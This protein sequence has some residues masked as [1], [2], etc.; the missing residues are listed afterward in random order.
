MDV[1]R[2]G[3]QRKEP[4]RLTYA[5]DKSREEMNEEED[6]HDVSSVSSAYED[7][8][9]AFRPTASKKRKHNGKKKRSRKKRGGRSRRRAVFVDEEEEE[10]EKDSKKR[11]KTNGND[12]NTGDDDE[13]DD[14]NNNNNNNN[15]VFAEP[16]THLYAEVAS[17]EASLEDSVQSFLDR[18]ESA[19]KDEANGIEGRGSSTEVLL[20]LLTMT[21]IS[22][23]GSS[24]RRGNPKKIAEIVKSNAEGN[25]QNVDAETLV[26][27]V[28]ENV[29]APKRYP[30]V[31]DKLFRNNFCE[32]WRQLIQMASRSVLYRDGFLD[33]LIPWLVSC[34]SGALRSLRHT[35]S[36]A[37]FS[38]ASELLRVV[39]DL[40]DQLMIAKRRANTEER[41]NRNS[42]TSSKATNRQAKKRLEALRANAAEIEGRVALLE[43]IVMNIFHGVF[44]HR[45]EDVDNAIRADA[46]VYFGLWALRSPEIVLKNYVSL[47][48]K[49]MSDFSSLVRLRATESITSLCLKLRDED[50]Q[51]MLKGF[52]GRKRKALLGLARDVD[53]R[54]C[55]AGISMITA[56]NRRGLLGSSSASKKKRKK[57][58]AKTSGSSNFEQFEGLL[59][60]GNVNVQRKAAKYLRRH[61]PSLGRSQVPQKQL[62][63]LLDIAEKYGSVGHVDFVV[64]AFEGVVEALVDCEAMT[65][66]LLKDGNAAE[67]DVR[68]EFLARTML[69]SFVLLKERGDASTS[70]LRGQRLKEAADQG[71]TFGLTLVREMPAL[72]ERYFAD[73]RVLRHLVDLP[74]RVDLETLADGQQKKKFAAL[75]QAM[76]KSFMSNS[77]EAVLASVAETLQVF[78]SPSFSRRDTTTSKI[79]E[80][81]TKLMSQ[82]EAAVASEAKV[83]P[84]IRSRRGAGGSGGETS[85]SALA[86]CVRRLRC[87]ARWVDI[88]T[89]MPT[90]ALDQFVDL[91]DAKVSAIDHERVAASSSSMETLRDLPDLLVMWTTWH[92]NAVC[93]ETFVLDRDYGGRS[94]AITDCDDPEALPDKIRNEMARVR[95]VVNRLRGFLVRILRKLTPS[96]EEEEEPTSSRD[97]ARRDA[98]K[99][100]FAS[101]GDLRLLFAKSQISRKFSN[102]TEAGAIA[103]TVSDDDVMTMAKASQYLIKSAGRVPSDKVAEEEEEDDDDES[104]DESDSPAKMAAIAKRECDILQTMCV[105]S[106]PGLRIAKSVESAFLLSLLGECRTE[107][108][109]NMIQAWCKEMAKRDPYAYVATQLDTLKRKFCDC[110]IDRGDDNLSSDECVNNYVRLLDLAKKLSRFYGVGCVPQKLVDAYLRLLEGGFHFAFDVLPERLGFLDVLDYYVRVLSSADKS[111][112]RRLFDDAVAKARVRVYRE[113]DEDAEGLNQGA[114]QAFDSFKATVEQS[115]GPIG[116]NRKKENE[117]PTSSKKRRRRCDDDD[118]GPST[119]TRRSAA[120]KSPVVVADDDDRQRKRTAGSLR[121]A[122]RLDNLSDDDGA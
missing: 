119:A 46:V 24:L 52:V 43:K 110:Q 94:V 116:R 58:P 7:D 23:T 81:V 83:S 66:L 79:G 76:E 82:F 87:L 30:I 89:W 85:S 108:G 32:F 115:K 69:V 18:Y 111:R 92:A 90:G 77:D 13:D 57:S 21:L 95:D 19:T 9:D 15:N 54:V 86:L 3:R 6:N 26:D 118:D 98:T 106:G 27:A 22:S 50:V 37:V 44:V 70:R 112:A 121:S 120:G 55:A 104:D 42:K 5:V 101:L 28:C 88:R 73:V 53:D 97:D 72:L 56:M 71:E 75:L 49:Q 25:G 12:N 61:V 117:P 103:M 41:K 38:V 109:D 113:Q 34:S 10:E 64:R 68:A 39:E 4:A 100:A 48:P 93:S 11:E 16:L 63:A 29:I 47:L 84:S 8:R 20:E 60:E 99:A 67:S 91:L 105:L 78:S 96:S 65:T 62:S 40:N 33:T 45:S 114:W 102:C 122:L 80:I 31:S 2:S 1:R 17:E 51:T 59:F 36:L 74:K 14:G 35:A 107:R